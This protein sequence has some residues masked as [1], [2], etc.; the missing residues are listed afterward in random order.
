MTAKTGT[1]HLRVNPGMLEA[2]R[3]WPGGDYYDDN[4]TRYANYVKP[5][6][7]LVKKAIWEFERSHAK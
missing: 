7:L 5:Y 3:A 1:N 4:G 2:S 6:A